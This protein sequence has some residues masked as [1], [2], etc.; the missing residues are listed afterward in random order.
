MKITLAEMTQIIHETA[1]DKQVSTSDFLKLLEIW[2]DL[3][4]KEIS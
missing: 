1:N 2:D 4:E 3:Y